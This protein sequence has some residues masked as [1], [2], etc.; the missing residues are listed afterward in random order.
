MRGCE[1]GEVRGPNG[2]VCDQCPSSQYSFNTS[3]GIC[4]SPCPENADC[5]GGSVVTPQ[6]GYWASAA[7]STLLHICPNQDACRYDTEPA[8]CMCARSPIIRQLCMALRSSPLQM[9]S[10]TLQQTPFMRAL[11]KP[12]CHSSCIFS[13]HAWLTGPPQ[14]ASLTTSL[15]AAKYDVAACRG[16][17][18]RLQTC[19]SMVLSPGSLSAKQAAQNCPAGDGMTAFS[20]SYLDMQCSEGYQGPLC[21]ICQDGYGVS[22]RQPTKSLDLTRC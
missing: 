8:A 9:L 3:E 10:N 12:T 16:N 13:V 19:Q 6:L 14:H 20:A 2:D 5:P 11:T 15:L 17:R 7:N 21:S 1:A 22:G 18:S 4:D